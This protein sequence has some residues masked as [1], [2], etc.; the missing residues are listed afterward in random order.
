MTSQNAVP[1]A[2]PNAVHNA[3]SNAV[4]NVILNAAP[5]FAFAVPDEELKRIADVNKRMT[6][7][8]QPG[9]VN[10]VGTL[11]GTACVA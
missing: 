2:D 11:A 7:S 4:P 1:N 6:P 3:A 5:T 10:G 9:H 8:E